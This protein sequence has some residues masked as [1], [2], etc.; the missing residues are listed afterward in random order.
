[1]LNWEIKKAS[2]LHGFKINVEFND[3]L[4]GIVKLEPQNLIKAFTPLK[5]E[6]LFLKGFV[7]YGAITWNVGDYELDLAPDS[8]Y[9]EIKHNSGICMY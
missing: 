3:G 4:K 8:M 2:F 1:M 7:Q 5:N 9:Q 6:N